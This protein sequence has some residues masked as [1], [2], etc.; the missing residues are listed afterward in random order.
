MS[1]P[2]ERSRFVG[3]PLSGQYRWTFPE[4]EVY[5]DISRNGAE[6][7]YARARTGQ[8]FLY[9]HSTELSLRNRW[10]MLHHRLAAHLF[11]WRCYLEDHIEVGLQELRDRLLP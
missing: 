10:M 7:H 2:T 11:V 6:H 3:G 4:A 9:D 1:G 5:I 8:V